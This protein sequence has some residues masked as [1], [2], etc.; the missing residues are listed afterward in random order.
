MPTLRSDETVKM[1]ILPD[2]TVGAAHLTFDANQFLSLFDR[3]VILNRYSPVLQKRIGLSHQKNIEIRG[4]FRTNY[5]YANATGYGGFSFIQVRKNSSGRASAYSG[6]GIAWRPSHPDYA[7]ISAV[8]DIAE[9]ETPGRYDIEAS[10]LKYPDN[11]VMYLVYDDNGIDRHVPIQCGGYSDGWLTGCYT[12]GIVPDA[13]MSV[14]YMAPNVYIVDNNSVHGDG[15]A[16]RYVIDPLT[17]LAYIMAATWVI[18]PNV[19]YYFKITIDDTNALAF[20]LGEDDELGEGTEVVRCG[21]LTP[22]SEYLGDLDHD[23]FGVSVYDTGGYQWWYDN[24][25]ISKLSGEYA[26][27]YFVMDV[28]EMPDDLQLELLAHASGV[29]NGIIANIWNP[30]APAQW[31]NILESGTSDYAIMVS[32][33]FQ[34]SVYAPDGYVTIMVRSMHP[35]GAL[36]PSEV[37]I[38][39]IKVIRTTMLG[40]HMGGCVDVYVDDPS[41]VIEQYNIE[42]P[43]SRIIDMAEGGDISSITYND[44]PLVYGVDYVYAEDPSYARSS[45][46]IVK[47]V[48]AEG[49]IDK[50]VTINKWESEVIAGAQGVLDKDIHRP[51]NASVIVKHKKIH[52]ITVS[53]EGNGVKEAIEGYVQGL[54]YANKTKKLS[55]SEAVAYVYRI[56]GEYHPITIEIK[57]HDGKRIITKSL[58]MPGQEYGI[59]EAETFRVI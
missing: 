17:G 51:L 27:A 4:S 18:K 8:T 24:L 44:S 20:H 5:D 35:S 22:L 1:S 58:F 3:D 15:Y 55:Y 37:H 52:E 14:C 16:S 11:G 59:D 29:Q 13:N 47:I 50:T 42:V 32:D 41:A 12:G 49:Y 46:G 56:V 28:S 43:E 54:M 53:P 23:S 36:Q 6:Y 48:F 9:S 21:P 31:D 38:D 7:T 40:M 45:L 33:V 25:T 30:N 57:S 26:V 2:G 10:V 19:Q 34:K 39:Y